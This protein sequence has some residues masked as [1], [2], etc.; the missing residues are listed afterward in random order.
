MG[1]R[2]QVHLHHGD[3]L[4]G[5]QQVDDLTEAKTGITLEKDG[6]VIKITLGKVT[7]EILG[8][9]KE[10]GQRQVTEIPLVAAHILTDAD[11]T[12]HTLGL[13]QLTHTD[14]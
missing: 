3:M 14:V 12:F 1:Q 9:I 8:V 5:L 4:L 13:E 11:E 10:M 2:I 7:D 6:F